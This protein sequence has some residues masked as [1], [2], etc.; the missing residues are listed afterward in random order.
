MNWPCAMLDGMRNFHIP[1]SIR[2]IGAIAR[3]RI[4][5]SRFSQAFQRSRD[6]ARV[7]PQVLGQGERLGFCGGLM[8]FLFFLHGNSPIAR[9]L[10][11]VLPRGVRSVH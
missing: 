11:R 5:N 10:E 4:A 7:Y 1:M 2:R 8:T 3:F 6:A 9:S